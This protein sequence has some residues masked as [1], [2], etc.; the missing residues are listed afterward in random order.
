MTVM[1]YPTKTEPMG[2]RVQDKVYKINEYFPFSKLGS[3][4]KEKAEARQAE[5]DEKRKFRDMSKKLCI[6][7]VFYPDGSVI[8]MKRMHKKKGIK[9]SEILFIQIGKNGKQVSTEVSLNNRTFKQAY[10][11]AQ[12]KICEI[13]EVEYDFE[14]KQLFKAVA[15][16]YDKPAKHPLD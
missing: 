6:N 3:K 2:Y 16:L 12:K 10:E 1:L 9:Y 4:A 14:M 7:Q 13:R 11:L 5:L 15:Y 8:G